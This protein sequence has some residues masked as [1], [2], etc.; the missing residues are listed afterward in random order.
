MEERP[1]PTASHCFSRGCPFA[2]SGWRPA[3]GRAAHFFPIVGPR[4]RNRL[5]AEPLPEVPA[6]THA[7]G[8]VGFGG[9]KE[10]GESHGLERRERKNGRTCGPCSH[11]REPPWLWASAG[12]ARIWVC[13]RA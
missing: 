4:G 3:P 10:K 7:W 8:F 5:R 2:G 6:T 11:S 1:G 13:A 12:G 9:G